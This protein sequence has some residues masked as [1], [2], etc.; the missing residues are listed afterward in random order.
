MEEVSIYQELERPQ[1]PCLS[2]FSA[3]L[4]EYFFFVLLP[5]HWLS[6]LLNSHGRWWVQVA[7]LRWNK[8]QP[9]AKNLN[10]SSCLSFKFQNGDF[11]LGRISSSPEVNHL[12][13]GCRNID[14]G[15]PH[16]CN[17]VDGNWIVS[18][19]KG[20]AVSYPNRVWGP[21]IGRKFSVKRWSGHGKG[22]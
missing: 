3:L 5:E 9:P 22:K 8:I 21:W 12:C 19:E 20:M 17:G 4:Q 18:W 15:T 10:V 6:L 2:P 11:S 7:A 16:T 13:V 1:P 14:L